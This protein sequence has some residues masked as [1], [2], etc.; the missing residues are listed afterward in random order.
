MT[1]EP[2]AAI[3]RRN[4]L[5]WSAGLAAVSSL[6]VTPAVAEQQQGNTMQ[7][8]SAT[9]T[10]SRHG[11]QSKMVGYMLAHEEFPVP[12]LVRLGGLASNAGFHALAT[13][14]HLQPWQANEG[15]AGAAW[16]TMGALG[17]RATRGWMG[18]TV[19]CPLFRY[20]PAVVAEA[21]AS[22]SL[23][24]PGRIFLGV[25]SGEALNERAA[26][27]DWPKWQERWDRLIEAIEVIRALWTGE[28]V[29][30]KGGHYNV[31]ARLYDPPSRPIP[32]L[33]AANGKKS[34]RL[35]GLHGDGLITDPHTWQQHKAEWQAGAR[36]AGKDPQK[37]PVLVEQYVVVGGETEAKQAAKLWRFGPKAF[38]NYYDITDPA[39]IQ[40]Q[41]DAQI[42]LDEVSEGWPIS[43]D[44]KSHIAKIHELFDSGVSIVNIH[45]GQKDQRRVIDFYGSH[46]LPKL[47]MPV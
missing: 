26:T 11:F 24:Y 19:T 41:A 2:Q 9:T 6:R 13:S 43:I 18:T 20:N 14:D 34:M 30:H 17:A 8:S 28:P 36:A 27:G 33:T 12:E 39:E 5:R 4:L 3:N 21:F 38:K 42:P 46:V 29:S 31:E 1:T 47:G 10:E 32:L 7:T 40:R 35:A 22:L 25:G 45:A 16:V 23:L 15:H 37:M 44:P